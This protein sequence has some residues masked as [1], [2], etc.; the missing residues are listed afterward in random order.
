MVPNPSE[1]ISIG[2][3]VTRA[4]AHM[5]KPWGV[6]EILDPQHGELQRHV[7]LSQSFVL[8]NTIPNPI[9]VSTFGGM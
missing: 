5:P 1:M 7:H 6:D 4:N 3:I 2:A 8:I 9:G